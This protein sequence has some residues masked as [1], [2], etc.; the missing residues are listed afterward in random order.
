MSREFMDPTP[1]L[2]VEYE[3]EM[4]RLRAEFAARTGIINKWRYWK[5]RRQIRRRYAMRR[6]L[7]KW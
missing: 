3:T 2:R 6:L 5:G 1:G 7:P 4:R